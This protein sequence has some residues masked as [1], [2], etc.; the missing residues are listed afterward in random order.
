MRLVGDI[1]FYDKI[2]QVQKRTKRIQGIKK[3]KNQFIIHQFKIHPFKI[4][5]D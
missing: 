2:S 4:Y 5:Q 1:F 3:Y